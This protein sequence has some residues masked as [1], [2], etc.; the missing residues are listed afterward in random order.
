[1]NLDEAL[2]E[3]VAGARMTAP[4]MQPGCYIE[5]SFSRG[6]LRC[7][8]VSS[9]DEEPTRTQCDFRANE[10]DIAADW[11]ILELVE[12]YPPK[13][14][15]SGGWGN[16]PGVAKPK[17]W[18]DVFRDLHKTEHGSYRSDVPKREVAPEINDV[19]D[20]TSG[21]ALPVWAPKPGNKG[22]W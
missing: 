22:G 5:H 4:H 21:A 10:L 1:M 14:K 19:I 2:S 20:L 3:C 16:V 11:R 7:W 18:D 9:A 13:P 17:T 15:L 12:Q 8:P 6:F